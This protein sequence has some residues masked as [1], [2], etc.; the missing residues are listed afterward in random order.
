SLVV[1]K[2]SDKDLMQAADLEP[3]LTERL[4][5]RTVEINA[6]NKALDK[7]ASLHKTDRVSEAIAALRG[8]DAS[9]GPPA[10]AKD[11][12][13]ILSV[14]PA[15]DLSKARVPLT[16]IAHNAK[17][18]SVRGAAYAALVAA[19]GKPDSIWAQ[20]E[21]DSAA[22]ITL[23]DSIVMLID[24]DSRARFEPLLVA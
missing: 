4:H 12:A 22:R 3:V 2:L 8:L 14:M 21:K 20:T 11:I 16:E 6:R 17:E 18:N 23:I 24:P 15:E 10:A 19:E 5:R 7:L 9:A 1:A 13:T